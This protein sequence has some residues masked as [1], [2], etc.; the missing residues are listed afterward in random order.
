MRNRADFDESAAPVLADLENL[1]FFDIELDPM[2]DANSVVVR[3]RGTATAAST[4]KPYRQ[5]YIVQFTFR[6]DKVIV[7]REY[8]NTAVLRDVRT[9]DD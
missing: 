6:G 7:Y 3:F 9:K 8:F 2:L 5:T 4:G 1:A